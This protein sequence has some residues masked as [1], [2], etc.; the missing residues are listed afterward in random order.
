MKEKTSDNAGVL[1]IPPLIYIAGFIL[2]LAIHFFYPLKLLPE[3]NKLWVA[4]PFMLMSLPIV[5][6][7][8]LDLKTAETSMDVRTPTTSVVTTGIY[9]LS[10]N[11]MYLALLLLYSG[12]GFWINSFWI[13]IMLV[14]VIILVNLG[15]IKREEEYLEQKFGD[16]YLQYKSKVRRWV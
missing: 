13:L 8:V 3:S 11:P 10:R 4:I 9:K 7:A 16:E 1:T 12:I 5:I 2:G 6:F 14:P 15:I